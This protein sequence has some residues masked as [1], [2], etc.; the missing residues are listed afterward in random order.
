[1]RPKAFA[2]Y[3]KLAYMFKLTFAVVDKSEDLYALWKTIYQA[4]RPTGIASVGGRPDQNCDINIYSFRGPC[5]SDSFSQFFQRSTRKSTYV[6]T[7]Y[8]LTLYGDDLN[9]SF[10]LQ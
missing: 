8:S 7:F 3:I 1:M 2:M 4:K 6:F 10:A 9:I 5:C